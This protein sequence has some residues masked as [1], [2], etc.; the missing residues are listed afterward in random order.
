MYVDHSYKGD[1]KDSVELFDDGMCDG[2]LLETGKQYLMYTWRTPTNAIPAR[3]CTRSRQVEDA[4]EDLEFLKQYS[5]GSVKTHINGTVVLFPDD[6]N[7]ASSAPL[8]DVLVRLSG[9]GHK[10]ETKTDALGRYSF[11]GVPSAKYTITA[12]LEGYRHESIPQD[13]F[14]LH[15]NGCVETSLAMK[16]D[17]R[18]EG[19]VRDGEGNPV[20]GALV[21]IVPTTPGLK[22]W[23]RPILLDIS[24]QGGHYAIDG[25][26]PGEFYLGVNIA[27]APTKESPYPVTYYPG[28]QDGSLATRIHVVPGAS[29]QDF[30][31]TVSGKLPLV[32]VHG[33]IV[34]PNG[35]PPPP[36]SHPEVRIK[37]PDLSG[38]IEQRSI[39]VDSQG[40][41][42]FELSEGVR[43]SAFAFW[44]PVLKQMYSAPVAF[45][46]SAETNHLNLVV[47][48]TGDEFLKLRAGF[49]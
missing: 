23:E 47:D 44:G 29:V 17:R 34:D 16:I 42:T 43:Y 41:F 4:G 46:P 10:F 3:G 1:L 18:V 37:E 33:T 5:T 39:V 48:K 20:T 14:T 24:Q 22:A 36:D 6:R 13:S 30:D 7:D 31:L 12:S 2:P 38:Q 45:T 40:R 25:I 9:D 49:R 32:E 28:T 15:A 21:Q 11:S 35:N 19:V 26:P 8:K 27:G